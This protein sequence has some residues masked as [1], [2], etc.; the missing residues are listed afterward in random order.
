MV[1]KFFSDEKILSR[2][3]RFLGGKPRKGDPVSKNKNVSLV[4]ENGR[5]VPKEEYGFKSPNRKVEWPRTPIE[6][7]VVNPDRKFCLAK[8]PFD[9]ASRLARLWGFYPDGMKFMSAAEFQDR[10]EVAIQHVR[11]DE[12]IANLL[13]GPHFPF[14][15]PQLEGD[16]GRLLEGTMVPAM[17]RSYQEEFPQWEFYNHCRREGLAGKVVV[18]HGTRQECLVEAMA[19]GSLCGVYFP[20]ALHGFDFNAARQ[21]M[22]YLPEYLLLSGME[23]PIAFA[24]Y[25]DVVGRY[26]VGLDMAG[27]EFPSCLYSLSIKA[28][29]NGGASICGD[30]VAPRNDH[31]GGVSVLG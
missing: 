13:M 9:Y 25:P 2:K 1:R 10:C 4:D 20:L 7:Y 18:S 17:R 30:Y 3:P 27:V 29:E 26:P 14:V 31:S 24:A 11:H 28:D 19:K 8:P 5:V 6:A 16:L 23:V 12:R 21:V 22:Q 15:I